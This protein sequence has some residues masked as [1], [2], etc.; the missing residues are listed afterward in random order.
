VG[1]FDQY[2]HAWGFSYCQ[3]VDRERLGQFVK[4]LVTEPLN[5]A[6]EVKRRLAA[7]GSVNYGPFDDRA[8]LEALADS[9]VLMVRLGRYISA[10]LLNQAPKLRY[11][12][13]ATTGL[14]HIDV[15]AARRAGVRVISLGEC[16]EAIGD[17]TATAEHCFGLI[18]ALARRIPWAADHVLAGG[19]DRDRF[20]GMQL[21]G[22]RLG[23]VGY[24]RIGAMVA[25]YA[26]AFGMEIVAYDQATEKVRAPAKYVGFD[27][28]LRSSDVVT[29]HVTAA[30]ENR[31]LI[32][33]A[34][35]NKIKHGAIVINTARSFIADEEAL[36]NA[37]SRGRLAGVAVDVLA[38]EERGAIE[39]SPL[40]ARGREGHSVIITPH[41][42]GATSESVGRT[43]AAIV[44][45]LALEL[46]KFHC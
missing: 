22:K 1:A 36:G 29:L 21:A 45:R 33:A 46:G 4:I 25:R 5:L 37:L 28:L 24:G 12:L 8:L 9:D 27:E 6:D 14:D 40:L 35:V 32:D 2:R 16:K 23:I 3:G 30:L 31:H 11:V 18:L 15:D 34:A 13:T 19:W 17:V 43:E 20:W 26:N 7:L 38:G 39:M 44:E 41:I 42:G 10:S